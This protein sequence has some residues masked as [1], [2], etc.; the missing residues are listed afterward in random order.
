[1]KWLGRLRQLAI[2]TKSEADHRRR[3]DKYCKAERQQ[4]WRIQ[5][6][7]GHQIKE[8]AWKQNPIADL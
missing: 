7:R 5:L 8:Q 1:M 6:Q 3:A 4:K 2:P